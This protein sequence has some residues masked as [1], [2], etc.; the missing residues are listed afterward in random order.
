[1]EKVL[2]GGLSSSKHLLKGC[3]FGVLFL[4]L[5]F[6]LARVFLLVSL[7][8]H[9]KKERSNSLRRKD[10]PRGS[11]KKK[12]AKGGPTQRKK[13]TPVESFGKEGRGKIRRESRFSAALARQL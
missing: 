13:D 9:P 1:M 6:F 11:L 2:C 12:K 4:L 10:T 3:V 8:S 5:P 7:Q